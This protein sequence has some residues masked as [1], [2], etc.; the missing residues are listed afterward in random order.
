MPSF[1][2]CLKYQ[3]VFPIEKVKQFFFFKKWLPALLNNCFLRVKQGVFDTSFFISVIRI[4]NF[5][6]L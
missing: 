3:K 2:A 6:H 5:Q 4:V 1:P